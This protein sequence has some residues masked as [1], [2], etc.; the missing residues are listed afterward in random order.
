MIRDLRYFIKSGR[1]FL[2]RFSF[3]LPGKNFSTDPFGDANCSFELY[4]RRAGEMPVAEKS[5]AIRAFQRRLTGT[6]YVPLGGAEG[7]RWFLAEKNVESRKRNLEKLS[8]G[9]QVH[10]GTPPRSLVICSEAAEK[11]Q[12]RCMK[13]KDSRMEQKFIM[14]SGKHALGTNSD[15]VKGSNLARVQQYRQ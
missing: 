3:S 11:E 15:R 4:Y 2:R 14:R 10:D 13:E 5:F 7:S 12:Y 8:L 6:F 9:V 1:K